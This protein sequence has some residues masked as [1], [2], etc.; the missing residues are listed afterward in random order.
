MAIA[1]FHVVNDV[2]LA[3]VD[4]PK[5]LLISADLLMTDEYCNY[6]RKN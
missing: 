4:E 2:I 1:S 6:T 5:V 3:S